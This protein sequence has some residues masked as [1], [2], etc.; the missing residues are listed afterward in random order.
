MKLNTV[1]RIIAAKCKMMEEPCYTVWHW[2]DGTPA[3][4]SAWF[5]DGY[6]SYVV[7]HGEYVWKRWEHMGIAVDVLREAV[8]DLTEPWELDVGSISTAQ[9]LTIRFLGLYTSRQP[10]RVLVRLLD[11]SY[12]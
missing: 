9:P 5:D 12:V 6:S 11:G 2:Q 4:L 7:K 1:A 8:W 3:A 10:R